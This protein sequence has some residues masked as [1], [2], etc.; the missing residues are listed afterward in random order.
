MRAF[1]SLPGLWNGYIRL[2]TLR[3]WFEQTERVS[4]VN[5]LTEVMAHG[6]LNCG[7]HTFGG[8]DM[9]CDAM[10]LPRLI[11]LL[12]GYRLLTFPLAS[13]VVQ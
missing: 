4:L 3:K 7:S 8:E 9:T 5:T 2:G 1:L 11:A 6:R 12:V 13:W 10:R